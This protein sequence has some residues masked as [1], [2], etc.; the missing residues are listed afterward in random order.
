[1]SAADAVIRR[2]DY[3]PPAFLVDTVTLVVDLDPRAT[4]VE[5]HLALRRNPGADDPAAPLHLD[6]DGLELH[7]VALD[8]TPLAAEA[9]RHA[10]GGLTIDA[11]PERFTL[12]TRVR[13]NPEANT[14]LMGLYQAGGIL[15]TQCEPEAFR[16]ITFFPDRPDV[17]ARF[18]VTLRGDPAR[19]PVMLANGN[20]VARDTL[21]DGRAR[22]VWDD[23]HPKP[24]Y[25]FAL[26]AGDLECVERQVTTASGRVVPVRMYV[27]PGNR[28]G[29]GHA[30]D[31][32]ERAMA[33]DEAR[34]ARAYDL[35]V[36]DPEALAQ[37]RARLAGALGMALATTWE[38]AHADCHDRATPEHAPRPAG[39]RALGAVCLGYLLEGEAARAVP[40][41]AAQYAHG[42]TMTE[43]LDALALLAQTDG[44]ERDRA[45]ADCRHRYADS[46][47]VLDKWLAIQARARRAD[48]LETVTALQDDPCYSLQ[49]PNRVRS[50]L[51]VFCRDNPAGFH[52]ADGGGYRLIAAQ[53]HAIDGVNPPLAAGLARYL[54]DADWV[55]APRRRHLRAALEDTAA[56]AALSGG[57]REVVDAG[58]ARLRGAG[59]G[60]RGRDS[61]A[62]GTV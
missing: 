9:Y 1:M 58:L 7:H 33:W 29:C 20:P 60:A 54:S 48:S 19:Y 32:V 34:Y 18:H 53:V 35:E 13:V 4:D 37:A 40:L 39:W 17:L 27:E 15:C 3:R 14:S 22:V 36:T 21:P 44:P 43:R 31:T 46:P 55:D 52:R 49:R 6:G 2:S 57:T 23:P 12:T 11:V 16:R 51:E 30:L 24:C 50:V 56:A 28:D 62:P 38:A 61:G 26:F 10:G 59:G 5:A 8:G 45:L 47:A 42:P 25:L 41:C